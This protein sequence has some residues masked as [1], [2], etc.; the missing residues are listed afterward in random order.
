MFAS[1]H[2][3]FSTKSRVILLWNFYFLVVLWCYSVFMF[4]G[5]FQCH[6]DEPLRWALN[7]HQLLFFS[8][9]DELCLFKYYKCVSRA[10]QQWFWDVLKCEAHLE[11]L[12]WC[13]F[14][15]FFMVHILHNFIISFSFN[16]NF[17]FYH[18]FHHMISFFLEGIVMILWF[19]VQLSYHWI[20]AL[21]CVNLWKS[22]F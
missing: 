16:F 7:S 2:A 9:W 12:C 17:H 15:W 8:N 21:N 13:N 19:L 3:L 18:L 20:N 4:F 6:I 14:S 5:F 22:V 11:S 1:H 10:P